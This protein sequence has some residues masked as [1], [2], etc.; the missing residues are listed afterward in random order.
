LFRIFLEKEVLMN[1]HQD[2]ERQPTAHTSRGHYILEILGIV[3]FFMLALLMGA[4]IYQGMAAFG[5]LWLL[6]IIAVLAY[7]AADFISGFV[8]FLADNFGSSE[9]PVLGPGFIGA[10]REHHEDPKGITRHDFIDTNGNNSLVSLP[11]M[12]L[13]WLVVPIETTVG[14]YFFGAFFLLLCLAVFLT[15]Q[16]HKWAHTED[17]PPFAVWLQRRGLILSKEHHDIHHAS[18]YDTYYC[19]TVGFWNP[20]L[21]RTR[22]FEQTERLLRRIVPGA[23]SRLR[24]EREGSLNER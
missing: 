4:E 18:P 7:L 1:Q 15:N 20:L 14:G 19:I 10:F 21:D 12:L 8:H 24:V 23:D 5:Y 17:P 13:V 9:M 2:T 6:P 3:S 22:F 11:F 16:F